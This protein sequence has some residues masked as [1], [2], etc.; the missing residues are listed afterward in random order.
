MLKEIR[1]WVQAHPY[2]SVSYSPW[3]GGWRVGLY[4]GTGDSLVEVS[5]GNATGLDE[6]ERKAAENLDPAS[7]DTVP[8]TVRSMQGWSEVLERKA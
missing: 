6:A 7:R 1:N 5:T 4:D 8:D 2:R 3:F